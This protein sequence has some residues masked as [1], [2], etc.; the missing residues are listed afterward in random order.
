[1][2]AFG[3]IVQ[4]VAVEGR[5]QELMEILHSAMDGLPGCLN[6]TVAA[7]KEDADTIWVSEVWENQAAHQA[8]LEQPEVQAAVSKGRP[9]IAQYSQ[10]AQTE[11][12]TG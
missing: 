6:H 11:P 1:M 4:I 12:M 10:V 2:S 5:R 3:L 9:L 7:S 8:A